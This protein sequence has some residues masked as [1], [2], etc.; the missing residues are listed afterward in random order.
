MDSGTTFRNDIDRGEAWRRIKGS[1][2]VVSEADR[3]KCAPPWYTLPQSDVP[4]VKR[5]ARRRSG[6]TNGVAG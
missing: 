6:E 3:R 2:A 4:A 1:S 5:P